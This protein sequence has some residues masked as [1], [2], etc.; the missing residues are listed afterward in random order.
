[1]RVSEVFKERPLDRNEL[2]GT[3]SLYDRYLVE[4]KMK[5]NGKTWHMREKI[6]MGELKEVFK[7]GELSREMY[8]PTG[9][10]N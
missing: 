4:L 2:R 6:H 8:V 10:Q 7:V 5:A 3:A 1:M 9:I